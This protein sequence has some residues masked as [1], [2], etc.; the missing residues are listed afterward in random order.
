MLQIPLSQLPNQQVNVILNNQF[1]TLHV[2]QKF[3][4]LFCDVSVN[5]NVIIQGVHCLNLN[6]IVR[7][8]YLGFIGD[9]FFFDNAGITDP[10]FEGL[11]NANNG[12]RYQFIY[13]FPSE[14]PDDYGL[15]PFNPHENS[16][17]LYW[18]LAF[19]DAFVPPYP[20]AGGSQLIDIGFLS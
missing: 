5:N 20:G 14:L 13:L 6:Y 3:W 10:D 15:G 2:Y 9:L 16:N 12:G 11:A 7:S 4:G 8:T 17:I 18:D 19:P 1:T